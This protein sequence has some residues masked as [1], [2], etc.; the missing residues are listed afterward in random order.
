MAEK[1]QKGPVGEPDDKVDGVNEPPSQEPAHEFPQYEDM[2]KDNPT[3][4]PDI[5]SG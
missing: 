1:E 4:E 3:E 2:P 5:P